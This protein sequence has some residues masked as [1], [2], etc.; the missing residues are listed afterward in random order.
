MHRFTLCYFDFVPTASRRVSRHLREQYC[1]DHTP[2]RIKPN[3]PPHCAHRLREAFG[4]LDFAG[5]T[6]LRITKHLSG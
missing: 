5:R 1:A 6:L 4:G 2:C 3:G